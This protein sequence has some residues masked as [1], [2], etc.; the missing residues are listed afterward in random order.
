MR[1][2]S[3][4]YYMGAYGYWNATPDENAE[5]GITVPAPAHP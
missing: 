2:L 4:A 3:V 5:V 1:N